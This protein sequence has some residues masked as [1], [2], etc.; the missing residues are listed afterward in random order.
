M[1][2]RYDRKLSLKALRRLKTV[3]GFGLA[4]YVLTMSF[5]SFDWGMS[6]EPH[7]FSTIYGLQFVVSQGL[8]TLCLAII[9]AS[10][11]ARAAN[12]DGSSPVSLLAALSIA[13]E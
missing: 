11:I 6:L 13:A 1:A 4:I 5:A 12:A 3:A 7:W 10:R 9:V 8:A 2:D